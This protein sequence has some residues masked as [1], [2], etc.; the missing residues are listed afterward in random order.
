[1]NVFW[2]MYSRE[3]IVNIPVFLKDVKRVDL[4]NY[5]T[6]HINTHRY[7]HG[8]YVRGLVVLTNPLVLSFCNIYVYQIITFCTLNLYLSHVNNN[9]VELA[10]NG[11]RVI[12]PRSQCFKRQK[13][14]LMFK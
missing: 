4:K 12:F 7:T 2:V 10:K 6:T 3:S 1:M 11:S 5:H 14:I 8:N 9:S 13:I